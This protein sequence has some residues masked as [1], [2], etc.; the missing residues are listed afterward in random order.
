MTIKKQHTIYKITP[1]DGPFVDQNFD[2]LYKN[3]VEGRYHNSSGTTIVSNYQSIQT[4]QLLMD[5]S[6]T[7]SQTLA[8]ANLSEKVGEPL[9]A[10][11]NAISLNRAYK[12]LVT[13]LTQTSVTFSLVAGT[14]ATVISTSGCSVLVHYMVIGS[15]P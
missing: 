4:G 10:V 8:T 6:G 11:A 1:E 14:V 3:K 15:N 2:S 7:V 9:V 5:T 13:D 12:I